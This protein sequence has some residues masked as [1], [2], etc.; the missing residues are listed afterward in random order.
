[1]QV[2]KGLS[3]VTLLDRTE[4]TQETTKTSSYSDGK[5]TFCD[6]S[7]SK[8]QLFVVVHLHVGSLVYSVLQIQPKSTSERR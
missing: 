4:A 1:M 3:H 7:A 2:V 8:L 6:K 5:H